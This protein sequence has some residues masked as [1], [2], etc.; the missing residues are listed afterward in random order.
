MVYSPTAQH[1]CTALRHIRPMVVLAHIKNP[2]KFLK[3][4]ANILYQA[5]TSHLY[6]AWDILVLQ[7]EPG[8]YTWSSTHFFKLEINNIHLGSS[9]WRGMT[10]INLY[11]VNLLILINLWNP[12][13]STLVQVHWSLLC[14]W[15]MCSILPALT[16]CQVL[17]YNTSRATGKLGL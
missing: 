5:T 16:A 6:D 1:R 11:K 3:C 8:L 9:L 2:R 12:K 13:K 10:Y 15:I 14:E 4:L 7:M 17:A